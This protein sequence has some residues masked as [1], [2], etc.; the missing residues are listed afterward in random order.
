VIIVLVSLPMPFVFV[1]LVLCVVISLYKVCF[2]FC[3]DCRFVLFD[4]FVILNAIVVLC[5]VFLVGR[6]CVFCGV[7]WDFA[8]F[9]GEIAG[10]FAVFSVICSILVGFCGFPGVFFGNLLVFGVGIICFFLCFVDAV[11][12]YNRCVVGFFGEI[13]GL[14]GFCGNL[15]FLCVL[16]YFGGF[17]VCLMCFWEFCRCLGLV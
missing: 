15:W 16:T 17:L 2:L 9:S 6:F 7:L 1:G 12:V 8:G 14:V 13:S 5:L 11:V 3:F 10:N 4:R